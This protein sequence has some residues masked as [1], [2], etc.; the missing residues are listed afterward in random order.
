M[1]PAE[2]WCFEAVIQDFIRRRPS[3]LMIVRPHPPGV[4]GRVTRLDYL[5]YFSQDRGFVTALGSY[6][7]IGDVAGYAAYN[8]RS[9]RPRTH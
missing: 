5:K 4:A 1:K 6:D 9:I 8:R 7:Y 2:R 3:L